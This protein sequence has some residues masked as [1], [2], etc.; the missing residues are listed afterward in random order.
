[1]ARSNKPL[2]QG[3]LDL[4]VSQLDA[5]IVAVAALLAVYVVVVGSLASWIPARR[6]GAVDPLGMRRS[7]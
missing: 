7:E 5:A 6:A 3:A 2:L 1:M 4:I